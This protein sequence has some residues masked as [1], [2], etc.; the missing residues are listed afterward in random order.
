VV[1]AKS[2]WDLYVA[3]LKPVLVKGGGAPSAV[4][5]WDDSFLARRCALERGR[6]WRALI[7]KN[8][9]IVQNDRHPLMLTWTFCDFLRSYAEPEY[10]N[11][12]Y[13]VTPLFEPGV[14]LLRYLRVPEML[15]CDEL[16]S[17]IY[18][19][20]MWMSRGNTTSSLHFDTH[21][22]LMLQLDGTKE[23]FL[24]HPNQSAYMYSDFHTKF[25]L[26]P[27]NT[28]RVDLE[29]FPEF[30]KSHA[31]RALLRPGD[32]LYIPDGW[33]HVVH[34]Y[35]GRN[36]AVAIEF[37]PLDGDVERH[38]PPEVVSRFHW[39]GL[40]WAEQVKIRYEMRERLGR[41]HYASAQSES[42]EAGRP[43]STITCDKLAPPALFADLSEQLR[44]QTS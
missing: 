43:G 17:S 44:I 21:D 1:D 8:N 26:S 34:S 28:D 22:N 14:T 37:Q 11:M 31:H 20:R 6:P 13:T 35:P 3:E 19:A 15:R 7:E 4:L 2:F 12:L 16:H 33:W 38:W 29:R 27:I 25:G 36:L 41:S 9:R 32:A 40:F 39:K 10:E 18:Q 42:Q 24:W 23:L 30:A 5:P